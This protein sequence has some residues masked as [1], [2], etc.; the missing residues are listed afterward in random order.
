MV[1]V[2]GVKEE[3][4]DTT[5]AL[6]GEA[7][8]EGM[9][10]LLE[11]DPDIIVEVLEEDI[12]EDVVAAPQVVDLSQEYGRMGNGSGGNFFSLYFHVVFVVVLIIN[13][14][15]EMKVGLREPKMKLMLLI[16]QMRALSATT[17][18]G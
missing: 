13:L 7:E 4:Q 6:G 1:E 14:F 10:N 5:E 2:V 15:S 12:E 17:L 8:G 3:P 16:I 18:L 9:L 11:V